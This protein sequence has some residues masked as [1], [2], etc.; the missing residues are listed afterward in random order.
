MKYY[1]GLGSNLGQKE[2]NLRQARARLRREGIRILRSSSLY[3]TEPVGVPEQPWFCNQV[4]EIKADF[5]PGELLKLLKKI[6][7]RMGR[8]T[9]ARKA[10]RIIDLDILLAE[11]I[12][13]RT[14]ELVI[15][16][17]RLEKRNFVLFPLVEIAPDFV[18]PVF[19]LRIED[20]AKKSED[21][22]KVKKVS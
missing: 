3:E 2:D 6:E 11:N 17:P 13:I 5:S 16:H 12:I 8:K 15:P 1:L 4:V 19:K 20:L 22:S 10:P 9:R 21:S 14:R 18:H 7:Q